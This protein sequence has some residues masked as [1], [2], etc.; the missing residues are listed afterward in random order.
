[1]KVGSRLIVLK[2]LRC[3]VL[4][5]NKQSVSNVEM[6][7]MVDAL[8]ARKIKKESLSCGESKT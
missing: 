7:G 6:N 8:H 2:L 3:I 5:A 1:M 4:H